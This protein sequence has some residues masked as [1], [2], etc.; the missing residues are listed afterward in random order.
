VLLDTTRLVD[1]AAESS[2]WCTVLPR[3]GGAGCDYEHKIEDVQQGVTWIGVHVADCPTSVTDIHIPATHNTK[4][5][6][7]Y[8]A[9]F[10]WLISHQLAVIFS[11]KKPARQP[12]AITRQY[13]SL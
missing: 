13:F 1:T 3:V 11:Q 4:S 8:S 9:M 2:C 5:K 6:I 7:D 12:P 10:V